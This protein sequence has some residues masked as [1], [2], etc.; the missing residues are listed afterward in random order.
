MMLG[1]VLI[2]SK[3]GI[4]VVSER[5]KYMQFEVYYALIPLSVAPKVAKYLCCYAYGFIYWG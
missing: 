1:S 2:P 3:K 4:R 5:D